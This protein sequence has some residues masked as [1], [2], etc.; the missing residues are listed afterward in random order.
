MKQLYKSALR[1]QVQNAKHQKLYRN[2]HKNLY[3]SV[4]ELIHNLATLLDKAY[5]SANFMSCMNLFRRNSV[6]AS[7]VCKFACSGIEM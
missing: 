1:R 6:H 7:K 3:R 2:L 5:W 4:R